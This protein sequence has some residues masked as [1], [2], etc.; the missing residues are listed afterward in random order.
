[1]SLY[2]AKDE[3]RQMADETAWS[4]LDQ[5]SRA[6]AERLRSCDS[7]EELCDAM[8]DL[9][10]EL[11]PDDGVIISLFDPSH[12]AI[13][14]RRH[15]GLG[16]ALSRAIDTLGTDPRRMAIR[17]DEMQQEERARYCSGRLE[18]VP[19]GLH[20]LL[21]ARLPRALCDAASRML[22]VRSYHVVGISLD[23]IP[24]GGLTILRRGE[25]HIRQ[26]PLLELMAGMVSLAIR[27]QRAEDERAKMAARLEQARRLEAIGKLAGGVAHDFNNTLACIRIA[28]EHLVA[29]TPAEHPQQE[30]LA[31][32]LQAAEQGEQTTGTLLAVGRRQRLQLTSLDLGQL[33]GDMGRQISRSLGSDIELEITSGDGPLMIRG[34][35]NALQR[36]ILNLALNAKDAMPQGGTL[37]LTTRRDP[38]SPSAVLEVE[39][40]GCGM[41]WEVAQQAFEAFFTTKP[42]GKGTGLGLAT[43]HGTISQ[44]R[45]RLE[46]RTKPGEGTRITILLPLLEA[47]PTA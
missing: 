39:D 12:D 1:V 37:R 2:R 43:V 21:V 32:I 44:H 17:A 26:A 22:G 9:S 3:E 45:G 8:A 20:E 24:Q 29:S 36:A 35:V 4:E 16:T 14:V 31:E 47:R 7:A 11:L 19:G 38:R 18:H 41:E 10:S 46:L 42:R 34:D 23:D 27:Q 25:P 28:T 13:T 5:L 30:V 33:I 6:L 15:Q 40:S